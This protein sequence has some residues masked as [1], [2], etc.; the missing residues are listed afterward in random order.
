MS[1]LLDLAKALTISKKLDSNNEY[2]GESAT[3]VLT[4]LVDKAWSHYAGS[5]GGKDGGIAFPESLP[6][7]R[8]VEFG[9]C[10]KLADAVLNNFKDAQKHSQKDTINLALMETAINNIVKYT[11]APLIQ[12]GDRKD[13]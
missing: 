8:G 6:R 1:T 12:V 13:F 5:L 4:S 10:N 3:L 9:T 11:T 7:K 2:D